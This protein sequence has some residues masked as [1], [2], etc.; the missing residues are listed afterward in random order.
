[1]KITRRQLRQIIKETMSEYPDTAAMSGLQQGVGETSK[2][3][4]HRLL[5]K[6]H[7]KELSDVLLA[8]E[9]LGF[10]ER[11]ITLWNASL[12]RRN[13]EHT[14]DI[15]D[16]RTIR[17]LDSLVTDDLVTGI[18]DAALPASHA[19]EALTK[20]AGNKQ[21]LEKFIREIEIAS[22]SDPDTGEHL[23]DHEG[24][25]RAANMLKQ[26]VSSRK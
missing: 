3:Q 8:L 19:K 22:T 17:Y 12:E 14:V 20:L 15:N 4:T 9:D 18:M 10:Y 24:Y 23:E 25:R 11:M 21:F 6:H 7:D 5:K 13:P 2:E 16:G 26:A 1:M